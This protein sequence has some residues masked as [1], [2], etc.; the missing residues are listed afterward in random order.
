MKRY[1]RRV[2]WLANRRDDPEIHDVHFALIEEKDGHLQTAAVLDFPYYGLD[3]DLHWEAGRLFIRPEIIGLDGVRQAVEVGRG[4]EPQ[5]VTAILGI[6]ENFV[7]LL[8]HSE[9]LNYPIEYW[10]YCRD[11]FSVKIKRSKSNTKIILEAV[12]FIRFIYDK[13]DAAG[14]HLDVAELPSKY[15]LRL[16][17]QL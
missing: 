14:Y 10:E 6:W 5:E 1:F 13:L 2:E 4:L 9:R 11:K 17:P 12:D 16:R 8:E 15:I 3:D 7:R